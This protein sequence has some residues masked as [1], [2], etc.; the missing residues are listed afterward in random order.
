MSWKYL[1]TAASAA[2]MT[3]PAHDA[4]AQLQ[5]YVIQGEMAKKIQQKSEISLDT[6]KKIASGCEAFAKANQ[7]SAAIVIVDMFGQ[8]VFFERLDGA[9]GLTQLVAA[10]R[11]AETALS[12][13]RTSREEMNRVLKGQTTEF[14][15]GFYND[16]FAVPGGVPI[17]VDDQM[18]GAVGVGGSND[19]E[20]C[21]RAGLD[22]VHVKQPPRADILPRRYGSAA[23]GG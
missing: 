16:M 20:A 3:V 19:D 1:L 11:K 18:L 14:H 12:S 9:F 2:V 5:N 13:R 7:A 17:V 15:E 23:G 4:S 22:A 8:E 10:R 21:A 6:A